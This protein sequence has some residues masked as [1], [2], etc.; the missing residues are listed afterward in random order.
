MKIGVIIQARYG[1][2]R[3]PGKVLLPLKG[4]SVLYHGIKRVQQA[5]MID[6][7]I[8]ATSSYIQDDKIEA[9]V[10]KLGL[11]CFRG[12]ESDVLSR[13]YLAAMENNFD[14]IV[15]ITSDCPLVDPQVIDKVVQKYLDCQ[16]NISTNTTLDEKYRTY[17]RGLDVEVFSFKSLEIAHNEAREPYQREHVTPY[18]Y[19]NS[20]KIAVV[21]NDVDYSNYRWT[22]DTK[23]DY[24]AIEKIYDYFYR[25]KHNFFLE[26]IVEL[27][28]KHPEIVALNANI[29]QKKLKYNES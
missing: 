28:R 15:R 8:I 13:Y 27:M 20:E 4:E 14:I 12:S 26:N 19:E 24:Q 6:Q 10:K 18:I 5:K 1:S 17:P 9:E 21:Q 23:E 3:L 2:T 22:L 7:I 16:P 29:E 11:T 25:G